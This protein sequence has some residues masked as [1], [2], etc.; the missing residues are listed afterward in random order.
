MLVNAARVVIAADDATAVVR[1]MIDQSSCVVWFV[2][3]YNVRLSFFPTMFYRKYLVPLFGCSSARSFL[4]GT[5]QALYP[6][7]KV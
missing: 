5:Q 2:A 1:R 4:P 6:R 7:N 3:T